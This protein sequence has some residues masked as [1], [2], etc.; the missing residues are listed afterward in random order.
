M[1][2]NDT[3]T[4]SAQISNETL[5]QDW[6]SNP[7]PLSHRDTIARLNVNGRLVATGDLLLWQA[8][9]IIGMVALCATMKTIK[10]R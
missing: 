9:F 5:F 6:C 7:K 8:A 3:I 10:F 2:E 4:K 1:N